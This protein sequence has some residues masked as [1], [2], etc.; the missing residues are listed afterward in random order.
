M[1]C[2]TASS[3]ASACR[4]HFNPRTHVGCDIGSL[5]PWKIAPKFQSTHPR[6]V[7]PVSRLNKSLEDNFN[8]RTHVGCD[9]AAPATPRPSSPYFNPRTHVG[10]DSALFL[11]SSCFILFQSTHPRGVR[12]RTGARDVGQR[13][14]NPRTHVGCDRENQEV[15]VVVGIS[16][17]APTWGATSTGPYTSRRAEISIHAPTWGATVVNRVEGANMGFQ[18]THPR[19]VRH[20][21]YGDERPSN[22]ISIHAPTWGATKMP[23]Y[24]KTK[25]YG[26]SIH[27]PTWGATPNRSGFDLSHEFQ[28]THPRGV[29]LQVPC[30]KCCECKFQSTH[31]RGVRPTTSSNTTTIA[32]FNPRTH[33]GC[34]S[35]RGAMCSSL[36]NFNPRTHVGCDD[37]NIPFHTV[38]S[39]F[40]STHPRG[41]RL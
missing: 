35:V 2:D 22:A 19:G 17:H 23:R 39:I 6:G 5:Q 29:R 8:P 25:I 38:F 11:V 3:T 18:S 33:V 4:S 41:V 24:Y 30:G 34:D 27:A 32:N 36:T 31:P 40:Q 28:S 37:Q 7:R 9:T 16:I 14:F 13:N 20:S 15:L 10:C 26:I 12:H 21:L 1:G